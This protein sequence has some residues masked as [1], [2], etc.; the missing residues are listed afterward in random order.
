MKKYKCIRKPFGGK[1]FH[2]IVS[3]FR[4]TGDYFNIKVLKKLY[5]DKG[6]YIYQWYKKE[7][8]LKVTFKCTSTKAHMHREKNCI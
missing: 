6:I 7:V 1:M 5:N 4:Y 3:A 2:S 8:K